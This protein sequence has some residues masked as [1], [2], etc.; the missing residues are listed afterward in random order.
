MG[1]GARA[2]SNQEAGRGKRPAGE[3]RVRKR[4]DDIWQRIGRCGHSAWPGSAS[5]MGKIAD[6]GSIE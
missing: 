4:K 5:A 6:G 1:G 2:K 3:R